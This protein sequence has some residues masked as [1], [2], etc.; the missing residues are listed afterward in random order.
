MIE[1][2]IIELVE[3]RHKKSG[4]QMVHTPGKKKSHIPVNIIMPLT[5]FILVACVMVAG[6]SFPFTKNTNTTNSRTPSITP[7]ISATIPT[8][9]Q[10]TV[11]VGTGN[12]TEIKKGNVTV[13]IG[14]Y[15]AEPP[16]TVFID[17]VS[18]GKVSAGNPLNLTAAIG[19][20]LVRICVIGACIQEDVLVISSTPAKIDVGE[21]FTKEVIRGPLRVSVGGFNAELPV[22]VDNA[23]VGNVSMNKPLNLMVG[24]GRHEVKVCVGIICE[25][26]TVDIKF[27][28]QVYIDF[29]EALKKVAEFSTPTIQIVDTR[30]V[31]NTVT[32]D[33]EF[34]NPTAR[35]LAMNTTIQLAYSYINPTTHWR[36]NTFKQ[37]TITRTIRAGAREV[38]SLNF[39]LTGGSAYIFEN[40]T[41][42]ETSP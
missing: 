40:P 37:G 22:F 31:G 30:R 41:I 25:N 21:R 13:S 5:L 26:E 12:S 36:T 27:A 2:T 1:G 35:D 17:N 42:Q 38:R 6:C 18:A 28:Q 10:T 19:H 23:S 32:V 29:G 34:I 9:H 3:I 14:D 16:A 8:V 15:P 7:S 11:P 33:V 4:A 24:E 20:H 39:A